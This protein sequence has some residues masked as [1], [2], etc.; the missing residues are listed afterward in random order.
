M[1]RRITATFTLSASKVI[2]LSRILREFNFTTMQI[3]FVT[4]IVKHGKTR[5]S[6]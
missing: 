4:Q 2:K 3:V 6:T 5:P 1:T